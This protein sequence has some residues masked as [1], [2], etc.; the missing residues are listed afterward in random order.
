MKYH[1]ENDSNQSWPACK[2][3]LEML[4]AP[5]AMGTRSREQISTQMRSIRKTDT[6]PELIVRRLAHRRGFR[7]RL[8]RRDLP[9]TPDLVFASRKKVIFV[10]GC[11]WHQ[12]PRCKR[13]AVPVAN[14]DWWSRKLT[15]NAQR[16]L[17]NILELSKL[18]WFVLTVWECEISET[19]HLGARLRQF[20]R[21]DAQ[22]S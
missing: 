15:R 16:D 5:F 9:G 13:A 11:F 22:L 17:A 20:L 21:Q 19:V 8:H 18:G 12:H 14:H 4:R 10:H 3:D 6:K 2:A 1:W 7:F